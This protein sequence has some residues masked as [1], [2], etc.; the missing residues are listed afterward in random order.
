MAAAAVSTA[1]YRLSVPLQ[2]AMALG[3]GSHIS[4]ITASHFASRLTERK[5]VDTQ[6]LDSKNHKRLQSVDRWEREKEI[7]IKTELIKKGKKES[8]K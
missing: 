8:K 2:A 4:T 3:R 7:K 5:E 1:R 6:H